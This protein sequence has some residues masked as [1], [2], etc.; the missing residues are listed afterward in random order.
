MHVMPRDFTNQT[1]KYLEVNLVEKETV[2]GYKRNLYEN[3]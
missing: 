2:N 1:E 3:L